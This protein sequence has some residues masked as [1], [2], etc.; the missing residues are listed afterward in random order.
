MEG[1]FSAEGLQAAE[2]DDLLMTMARELVTEKGIGQNAE[3]VWRSIQ[4][5]NATFGHAVPK[6]I[7]PVTEAVLQNTS[8]SQPPL[9]AVVDQLLLFSASLSGT[10]VRKHG[11]GRPAPASTPNDE[12]LILF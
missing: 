11:T 8:P 5:Q 4:Q 3:L 10:L 6:E 2:D 7:E 1:K 12:Q 9:S